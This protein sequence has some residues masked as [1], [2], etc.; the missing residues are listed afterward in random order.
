MKNILV[1]IIFLLTFNLYSQTEYPKIEQDSSGQTVVLF[2]IEQAQEID[3]KLELLSL[4][5]KLN[6]QINDYDNICI[7]VINEKEDIIAR[8]DIQINQLNLLIENK[9]SQ[10][11][12]L[13]QQIVDYQAKELTYQQELNN[14]DKEIK[15]HKDKISE[16][17]NKMILGS[18]I[19]GAVIIGLVTLI[20]SI[21]N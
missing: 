11:N 19:G 18:S 3:N 8:Q 7:K 13:K 5:E 1:F 17:R 14:K 2:T 4:F 6:V 21:V 20:I 16:Q 12:N 10:I 15:L 9:D